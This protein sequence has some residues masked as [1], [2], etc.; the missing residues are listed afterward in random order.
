VVE[1]FER[2]SEGARAVVSLAVEQAGELG[3]DSVGTQHLLLG[4]LSPDTGAGYQVLHGA[5]TGW[6]SSA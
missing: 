5:G 2:F 6:G 4:L 1:L 3:H